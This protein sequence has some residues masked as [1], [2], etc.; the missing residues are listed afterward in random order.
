MQRQMEHDATE[1]SLH[2][3]AQLQQPLAQC[4][5]LGAGQFRA[6]SAG[7]QLLHQNIG[8]GRHQDAKLLAQKL[9]QLVRST[10]KP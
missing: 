3:H 9:E 4:A 1:R 7:S 2:P 10:S 6:C 5:D 8:S